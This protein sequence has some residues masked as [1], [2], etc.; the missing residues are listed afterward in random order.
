[1]LFKASVLA[2]V[3]PL[4]YATMTITMCDNP[5]SGS[6][7]T[8]SWNSNDASADPG[9]FSLELVRTSFHD[10]FAIANNVPNAPG[11]GP[12]STTVT[13]P[14]VPIGDGYQVEAVNI[15]NISDIYAT[16]GD[17]SVAA[18]P[19]TSSS[20]TSSGKGS[21]TSSLAATSQSSAAGSS[22]GGSVGTVS[23]TSASTGTTGTQTGSSS[24]STPSS[25]HNGATA[26]HASGSYA[27]L[28]LSALAGVVF[29]A[30]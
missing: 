19:S 27:G 8:I 7:C 25:F 21:Q 5:K 17:F 13:L 2:L 10:T 4:A 26:K 9:S 3:A 6:S 11:T 1:M 15:G 16:S 23:S 22:T 24:S 14:A 30:L 28:A 29:L 12:Q 20:S 18:A